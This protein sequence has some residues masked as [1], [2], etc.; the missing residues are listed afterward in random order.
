MK[1]K[2]K[3]KLIKC[4]KSYKVWMLLIFIIMFVWQMITPTIERTL[5]TVLFFVWFA[6]VKSDLE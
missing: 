5:L 4:V 1:T 2:T 3:K 6:S